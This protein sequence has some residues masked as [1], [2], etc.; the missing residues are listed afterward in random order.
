MMGGSG[1]GDMLGGSGSGDMLGGPPSMPGMTG[2]GPV[3]S[4][5]GAGASGPPNDPQQQQEQQGAGPV[6]TGE[7]VV[8]D[9]ECISSIARD[10]GHFWETIWNDPGNAELQSTRTD[11]NVLLP[12]DLLTVPEI[13]TKQEPGQTEE[14]H[15]FRR[16]G[17]PA[18]LRIRLMK[19]PDRDP[20]EA[21][22]IVTIASGKDSITEDPEPTG[23]PNE[24][25][26]RA[27]VPYVLDIEGER[28]EGTTDADGYLE[29]PMPGNAELGRLTLNP[30][31]ENQEAFD[32]QLGRLSPISEYRGV[33]E[34]LCNLS[35]DCGDRTNEMTDGLHWAIEAFQSKHGLEPTGELTEEVRNKIREL[36]GS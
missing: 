26:P 30:G 12:G 27:N 8:Q 11:P 34:R 33:K 4:P 20:E 16:R 36:H 5:P 28:H 3:Q 18:K 31:T 6:G 21:P 22:E 10:T 19:E 7:H 15:R 23:Q 35:F 1:S 9:G 2:G 24:D 29:V 25:E 17:E 32:L 13:R 14:H